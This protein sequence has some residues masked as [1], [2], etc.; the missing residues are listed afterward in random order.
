MRKGTYFYSRIYTVWSIS[1][2]ASL[3]RLLSWMTIY[4]FDSHVSWIKGN[5]IELNMSAV[6]DSKMSFFND[7]TVKNLLHSSFQ[8][9]AIHGSSA[10]FYSTTHPIKTKWQR[11]LLLSSAKMLI[12][13]ERFNCESK[14]WGE[15]VKMSAACLD[16]RGLG[17]L[18]WF[19][20]DESHF[21]SEGQQRR[22]ANCHT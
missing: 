16:P 12:H 8:W 10:D 5:S 9:S 4:P 1:L 20:L 3:M 22:L 17:K 14:K 11:G 2:C 7:R 15:D 6:R 18:I 21:E 19:V 13:F